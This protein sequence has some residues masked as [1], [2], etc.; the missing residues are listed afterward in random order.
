VNRKPVLTKLNEVWRRRLV[1]RAK[2]LARW[3]ARVPF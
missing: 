3:V 1:V 2:S